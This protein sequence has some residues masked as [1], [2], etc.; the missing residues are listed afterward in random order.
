MI[1]LDA[2]VTAAWFFE[3]ETTAEIDAIFRQ[4]TD[5]GAVVPPVWTY[6]VANVFRTAMRRRRLDAP[7]RQRSFDILAAMPIEH[8]AQGIDV[9]TTTVGLSDRHGL[10]V[11][12]ASY[13]ELAIRRSLPLATLDK[14]L[15]SAARAEGVTVLP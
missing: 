12:D 9:W 1:V 4:I 11:Y 13:L 15:R 5:A 7:R 6:E 8:D 3:D 10:S 14:D 2:S